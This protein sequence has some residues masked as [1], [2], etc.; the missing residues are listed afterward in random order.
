VPPVLDGGPDAWFTSDGQ[1]VGHG[2]YSRDGN[3][4]KN[5][6]IYRYPNGMEGALIWFHNHTLGA[7]RLNVYCGLAGAYLIADPNDTLMAHLPSLFPLVIQDRMFDQNGQFFFPADSAGGL[8]WALNPQHPYWVPEFAGD[9]IV[10]NGKSWP[11]MNVEP[12]RY[13]FLFIQGS[14]ART[15]ELSL[16]DRVS[17]NPGPPLWVIGT[18]GGFLDT[19]VKIDPLAAANNK[20]VQVTRILV[21]WAPTDLA[22]NLDPAQLAY[23]FDPAT[24]GHGYVWHCHIVDHK[25]NEMMRPDQLLP[26]LS[27]G[28]TY[29]QGVDY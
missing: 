27:A 3:A 26:N 22:A 29:I 7:T 8:L 15:Y 14:N 4:P 19:S 17:K 1:Y 24:L 13:T 5:Y 6:C 2:Y 28:R 23:P 9:I 16:M 20:L 21:R 10:V 12:K 11:F 25:D 18:D